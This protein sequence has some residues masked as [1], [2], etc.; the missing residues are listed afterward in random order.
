MT[1]ANANSQPSNAPNDT[2]DIVSLSRRLRRTKRR[3]LLQHLEGGK[4]GSSS[5]EST[6]ADTKVSKA[7]TRERHIIPTRQVGRRLRDAS[8]LHTARARKWI[9]VGRD[10]P[11]ER[12]HHE[13]TTRNR[14]KVSKSRSCKHMFSLRRARSATEP[15]QSTRSNGRWF[16][17]LSCTRT[18]DLHDSYRD[19]ES[20]PERLR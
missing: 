4:A 10:T 8:K 9:I 15:L 14:T 6:G 2:V 17:V 18:I 1:I 7:S 13:V 12:P 16:A 20:G 11:P 19:V 3:L 5:G